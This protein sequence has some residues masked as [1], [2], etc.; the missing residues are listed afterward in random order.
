MVTL[1]RRSTG[2]GAL[3]VLFLAAVWLF[4]PSTAQQPGPVVNALYDAEPPPG[5]PPGAGGEPQRVDSVLLLRNGEMLRGQIVNEGDHYNVFVPGGEIHVKAADVQYHCRDAQEAY[6]RKRALIRGDSALDHLELARWCL[7][8]GLVPPA[9]QE[10]AEAAALEPSHPLIPVLERRVKLASIPAPQAAANSKPA[11]LG[12]TPQELDRMVRGMPPKTVELF[13]QTI[14]PMLVNHCAAAGCHG[15]GVQNGFRLF[16]TPSGS[17]PSRLLTQRNLHAALQWLD[18]SNPD[19]SPLL[20]YPTR[21]HGTAT[22]PVFSDKQVTQFKQLREWCYRVGQAEGPVMQASY[23]EETSP[24]DRGAPRTARGATRSYR[25]P[26]RDA[27]SDSPGKGASGRTSGFHPWESA[28][29]D[30]KER[31]GHGGPKR[32]AEGGGTA[33]KPGQADPFDPEV[34]NRQFSSPGRPIRGPEAADRD[35]PA[36]PAAAPQGPPRNPDA[37]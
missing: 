30:L 18:R 2:L 5:N 9:A 29:I 10:L 37:P 28:T 1:A 6:F 19:A 7:K 16:R 24:Q 13:A 21:P 20:N 15:Q 22:I 27:G 34:F 8:A 25:R 36:A 14:Q 4:S 33:A 12:P 35:N 17:P 26:S 23:L 31:S 3:L 11:S 32:T